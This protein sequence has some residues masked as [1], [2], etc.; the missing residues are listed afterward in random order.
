MATEWQKLVCSTCGGQLVEKDKKR[1]CR[2]CGSV[3]EAIE[4]IS[5]EEVVALNRATTDRQLLRFDE[6]LEEYNLLL[7]KYPDNEMANWGA[8]L[9]DYGII[10]EQDYNGEY[11]PTCHRLN[12]R[13]VKQSPYYKKLSV[14]HKENAE[15]IERLRCSIAEKAKKIQPY[16]VFICYKATE[17]K[18][19]INVPTRE[20]KWARDIYEKLVNK[21]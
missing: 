14:A 7:K 4:K 1:V 11:I 12:E 18:N 15:K 10:Y 5:E 21:S 9:C 8:F 16:D 6:A 2:H 20:S 17:E 3:Y 19:G 13:P